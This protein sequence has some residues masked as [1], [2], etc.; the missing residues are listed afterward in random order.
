MVLGEERGQELQAGPAPIIR[1][2]DLQTDLVS[3][4]SGWGLVLGEADIQGSLRELYQEQVP[5]G[6]GSTFWQNAGGGVVR[7]Q[8]PLSKRGPLPVLAEPG[9]VACPSCFSSL[10]FL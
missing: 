2:A 4:Y 8:T 9:S 1:N 7:S 10:R 6:R 5:L 3:C